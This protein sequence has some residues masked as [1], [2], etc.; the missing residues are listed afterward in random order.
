MDIQLQENDI[1]S[2]LEESGDNEIQL[3]VTIHAEAVGRELK[4]TFSNLK[5][6][7]DLPGFRKGKAPLQVIKKKYGDRVRQDL[8]KRLMD[9]ALQMAIDEDELE[10]VGEPELNGPAPEIQDD[11][12]FKFGVV[13]ETK[14]EIDVG[15]YE[16]IEVEAPDVEVT[17]EDVDEALESARG[18][19]SELS[20]IE[21]GTVRKDDT[22][23][24]D[25]TLSVD[26]EQEEE[27]ENV[28]L[29][30]NEQFHLF[31]LSHPSL[32]T[33]FV[34]LETGGPHEIEIDLPDEEELQPD[35]FRGG[36]ATVELLIHEI[37]R[38]ELPELD[39]QFAG[40]FDCDSVDELRETVREEVRQQKEQQKEEQLHQEILD[41]LIE[42]ADFTLPERLLEKGHQQ[43]LDQQQ[44]RMAQAGLPREAIGEQ[45]E[46]HREDTK[47]SVRQNMKRQYVV[48]E[49]AER[50]KIYVTESEIEDYIKEMAEGQDM[51]PH[52]LKEQLEE[53][54]R[55]DSV[56]S[57]L[58]E[59][60]VMDFLLDHVSIEEKEE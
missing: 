38:P 22:L 50:E 60:K 35:A 49:V 32:W 29:Q 12:P 15:N 23:I 10:I 34:D 24:A 53:H 52:E 9:K 30:I 46:K 39:E 44:Q 59:Q 26:G 31:G 8:Q 45:L 17:E 11:E 13:I 37:K 6:Q 43:F 28:E 19:Y 58:K 47:D 20:W 14:P 41:R 48:Q 36:T 7:V 56:R 1:S 55:M 2:T 4:R 21:E 27:G 51:W 5:D 3:D 16:D 25:V 42:R 57:D 54:D 33:H 40:R 18:E